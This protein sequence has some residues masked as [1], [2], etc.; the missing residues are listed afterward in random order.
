LVRRWLRYVE[1][2]K[3][4]AS[5]GNP[6][7]EA[8]QRGRPTVGRTWAVEE[9]KLLGTMKDGD[10]ADRADDRSGEVPSGCFRHVE[11]EREKSRYELPAVTRSLHPLTNSTNPAHQCEA[12]HAGDP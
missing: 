3:D 1:M 9:I 8:L 11:M 5:E 2:A 10:V 7:T 6:G 4:W 12:Y